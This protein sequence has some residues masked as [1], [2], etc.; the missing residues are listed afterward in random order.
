MEDFGMRANEGK[1]FGC[2]EG[3]GSALME[4]CSASGALN[5]HH[6]GV[7]GWCRRVSENA[8]AI[9]AVHI[10]LSVNP[11]SVI[12]RADQ[13]DA[14]ERKWSAQAGQV[15]EHVE[16]TAAVAGR[17]RQDVGERILLRIGVDDF[18]FV[19]DPVPSSEDT[20]ALA[21]AEVSLRRQRMEGNRTPL[22]VRAVRTI[23]KRNIRDFSTWMN[24]V[25]TVAGDLEINGTFGLLGF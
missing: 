4:K 25:F 17:F 11:V 2:E 21:H 24:L 19:D 13:A 3:V 1:M 9:D 10:T 6:I 12:I 20:L 8:G 16:W 23:F 18:Q 22:R 15:K 7:G 5:C 14:C